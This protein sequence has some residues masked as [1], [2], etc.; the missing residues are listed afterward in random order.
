MIKEVISKLS[1]DVAKGD[2]SLGSKFLW[3]ERKHLSVV[4]SQLIQQNL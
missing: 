2:V 3:K 1:G 4:S